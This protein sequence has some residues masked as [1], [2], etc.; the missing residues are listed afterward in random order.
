MGARLFFCGRERSKGWPAARY[1]HMLVE[2]RSAISQEPQRRLLCRG[3]EV[4]PPTDAVPA[5][6]SAALE[7]TVS[8]VRRFMGRVV[9]P[10]A[11]W[12]NSP[13]AVTL[14]V[15]NQRAFGV[16]AT[17]VAHYPVMFGALTES[18]RE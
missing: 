10:M 6:V 13:R 9:V 4:V 2:H 17:G 18:G 8:G 11:L 7:A 14:W 5:A 16:F 3:L 1:E 12:T 15:C